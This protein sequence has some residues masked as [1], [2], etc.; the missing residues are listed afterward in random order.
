MLNVVDAIE[1]KHMKGIT[2]DVGQ[3]VKAKVSKMAKESIKV[4]RSETSKKI[5]E[6]QRG[7]RGLVKLDADIKTIARSI[8]QGNEKRK[9]R[10]KNGQASAFDLQAAQVVE[11]AL[12]GT[13]GNIESVRV[14][15]QMQEKI[16][17]SIVY[18]M[19]YEY[20]ADALCGRRQFYEYR[21][22]FIKRVASAMDM[23]PE[24]K[25]QEHGN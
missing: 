3:G 14:R 10:I 1:A 15:R 16:Y 6:E 13:C 22:E 20:I 7:C 25:G 11:N 12:R 9:K 2:I 21:Q 24:Q 4:E 17:K 8:I 19:P 23:L 18:N 5:Y